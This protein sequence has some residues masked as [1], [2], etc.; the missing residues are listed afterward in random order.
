[1]KDF[2]DWCILV[3]I[4]YLGYHLLDE[5]SALINE[6]KNNWNNFRLSTYPDLN[7]IVENKKNL[8]SLDFSDKLKKLYLI[9]SLAT[10]AIWN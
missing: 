4:Y 3:N 8:S 6:I 1:M 5:G 9:P 10:G 7:Q 2:K